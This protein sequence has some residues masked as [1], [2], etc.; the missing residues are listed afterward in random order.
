MAYGLQI[1]D[2]AGNNT[3]NI[4]DKLT[5]IVALLPASGTYTIPSVPAS[6]YQDGYNSINMPAGDIPSGVA[7]DGTWGVTTNSTKYYV[8]LYFDSSNNPIVT[9]WR[10][11]YLSY[12][13]AV[14]VDTAS[15]CFFRY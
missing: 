2:S 14:T 12:D 9:I 7:N 10:S 4:T 15:I 6:G 8:N 1:F 11:A 13:L 3:L 5:R